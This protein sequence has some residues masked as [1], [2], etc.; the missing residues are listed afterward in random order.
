[1]DSQDR[2]VI[3]EK[4]GQTEAW[5]RT[6]IDGKDKSMDG[7]TDGRTDRRTN[8]STDGRMGRRTDAR[9]HGQTDARTGR[10][11][12]GW[13]DGCTDGWMDART[14]ARMDQGGRT[15]GLTDRRADGKIQERTWMHTPGDPASR[16]QA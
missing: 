5:T 6:W 15:V 16:S 1:M 14:D 10:Q 2:C 12:H 4:H 8:G 3:E 13:A 9:T 11:T 7:W